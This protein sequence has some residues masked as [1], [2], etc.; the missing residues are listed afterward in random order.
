MLV[1]PLPDACLCC[2]FTFVA[3][4]S[5]GA[6]PFRL[7]QVRSSIKRIGL[8]CGAE[9]QQ[10]RRGSSAAMT[11]LQV[12]VCMSDN[13]RT[14][15]PLG[16]ATAHARMPARRAPRNLVPLSLRMKPIPAGP[17]TLAQPLSS[18]LLMLSATSRVRTG[19]FHR[20]A[21][22]LRTAVVVLAPSLSL[23]RI[24]AQRF[25]SFC[26]SALVDSS[27]K[28]AKACCACGS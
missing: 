15:P 22:L 26:S 1:L 5:G 3:V 18:S 20:A 4:C 19:C 17:P 8:M 2:L 13:V 23:C 7:V 24:Q 16:T 14:G 6:V 11:M 25:H 28:Y 9:V 27:A 21:S 12:C 10:V